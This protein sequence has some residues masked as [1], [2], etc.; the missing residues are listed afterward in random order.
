MGW[1]EGSCRDASHASIYWGGGSF[2]GMA[3]ASSY[4]GSRTCKGGTLSISRPEV[5][6]RSILPCSRSQRKD[7]G[8]W[9]L[10]IHCSWPPGGA[11][12]GSARV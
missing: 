10:F 3:M 12:G 9:E 1:G 6:G 5:Q 7:N 11:Q 2:G 8:S 4:G